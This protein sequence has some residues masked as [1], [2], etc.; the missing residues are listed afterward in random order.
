MDGAHELEAVAF[1]TDVGVVAAECGDTGR[2]TKVKRT[3]RAERRHGGPR[4]RVAGGM[5][6]VRTMRP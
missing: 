2:T 4:G 5:M 6:F 3:V 1:E